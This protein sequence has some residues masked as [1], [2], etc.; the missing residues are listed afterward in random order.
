M[1]DPE[2]YQDLKCL[3]H[4]NAREE[5]LKM[6]LAH[7]EHFDSLWYEKPINEAEWRAYYDKFRGIFFNQPP[8]ISNEK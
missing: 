6:V 8:M 7:L 2:L 1:I 3:T 5:Y 4:L